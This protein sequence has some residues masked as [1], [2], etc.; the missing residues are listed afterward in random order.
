MTNFEKNQAK[1]TYQNNNT[2]MII[3]IKKKLSIITICYNEPNLEKT[4]E[5]IINQTWQNFEWIVVDGGSNTPTQKIWN[6]Y[7]HRIDT[8]ISEPDNGIYNA[9][10]KGLKLAT[11]EFVLFMNAGDYFYDANVLIPYL[12][13]KKA[14]IFYGDA[15][16]ILDDKSIRYKCLPPELSLQFFVHDCISHPSTYI[17]RELF[18][19]YGYY[20][21]QYKIVSDWEKWIV[22]YQ[23][24]AR[25][26]HLSF[27]CATFNYCG[28]SA[29]ANKL[30]QKERLSVINKYNLNV[31]TAYNYKTFFTVPTSLNP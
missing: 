7:K 12:D 11:G 21:E 6:K 18:E 26:S 15:Q 24:H 5:S 20:D 3:P 30:N 29:K 25:Y 1:K 2:N 19:K 28:I 10:N 23:N 14:D 17:K 27:L 22:F 31:D 8:F 13:A 4:C 9:M 16:F